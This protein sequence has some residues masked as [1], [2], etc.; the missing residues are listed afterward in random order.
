MFQKFYCEFS[1]S[2]EIF[3][4]FEVVE[5]ELHCTEWSIQENSFRN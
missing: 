1:D 2:Y 3:F 5:T 4:F